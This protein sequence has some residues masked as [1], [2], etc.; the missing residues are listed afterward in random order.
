MSAHTLLEPPTGDHRVIW[1]I[2]LSRHV[3]PLVVV[4]NERGIFTLLADRPLASSEVAARLNFT[5]E[6]AAILLGALAAL[7]LIRLLDGRFTLTDTARC[8]LLPDSPYY[9]GVT[10]SRDAARSEGAQRLRTALDDTASTSA[11]YSVREWKE[12]ELSPEQA[13]MR[14]MHG[15]SFPAA[16]GMA[17][18]GDFRGVQRLL[19]VAGG[20]GG[21]SIALAQQHPDMHCTVADLPI[22]C[23]QTKQFIA[24]YGVESQVDTTPLNMFFEPWPVGYDAIFFSCVLHDWGLEQ[25]TELIG[26]AFD[27]LPAGGRV[28]I[29]E[30]LLSDAGDGPLASALFSLNMRMGT[31]GRQFTVPELRQAL[32]AAGFEQAT[33]QNTHGYFSLMS[34]RK[35]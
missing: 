26:R 21:C 17:R 2:L 13:D 11:R 35:P 29:H 32:D 9:S 7:D 25:R 20:S 15:R 8:F 31:A 33:V 22:V 1:D 34:A 23:E 24:Q 5:E 18:N 16:V 28:Y 12:G 6:W 30:L 14:S 4:S 19:D 3:L 10:L 27:A